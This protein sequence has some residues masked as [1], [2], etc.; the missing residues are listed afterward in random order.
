[1]KPP[2]PGQLDL[3]QWAAQLEQEQD[4]IRTV[5][6]DRSRRRGFIVFATDP[7]IDPDSPGYRQIYATE[8]ATP[9][10]AKAKIRPLAGDRRLRAYLATGPYSDQLADA[11]WVPG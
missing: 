11:Q 8:A 5:N 6:D 2:N 4:R 9:A 7:A 1:M 10:Q 3:F